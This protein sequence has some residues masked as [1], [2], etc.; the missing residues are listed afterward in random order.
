M[1]RNDEE[2]Y[3]IYGEI[4]EIREIRETESWTWFT[5]YIFLSQETGI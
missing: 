2:T 4:R 5:R 3:R 1:T